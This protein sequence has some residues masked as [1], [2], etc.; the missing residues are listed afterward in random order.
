MS[1]YD[2]CF[3]VS[4]MLLRLFL[5]VLSHVSDVFS[6]IPFFVSHSIVI[7][8]TIEP[9]DREDD[10]EADG[11]DG[12][13]QSKLQAVMSNTG[14][15]LPDSTTENRF[16]VWFTGGSLSPAEGTDMEAWADTFHL[17]KRQASRT[18]ND[19][20]KVLAAKL[21]LGA[22]ISQDIADGS[23]AYHFHRP[24]PGN[25]DVLY[26]DETLQA[27]KGNRGSVM[28]Q[29]RAGISMPRARKQKMRRRVSTSKKDK[30][31]A[32]VA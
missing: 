23:M 21:L 1:K 24:I 14:Y 13:P 5:L 3:E 2:I 26:T 16:H 22:E 29:S 4:C 10:P 11:Q 31:E 15:M 32:R 25:I 8:V 7:H 30:A 20:A 17:D 28:V 9:K 27:L 6:I 12:M 18:F 19:R